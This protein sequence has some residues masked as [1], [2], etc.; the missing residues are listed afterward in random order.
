[1]KTL[2]VVFASIAVVMLAVTIRTS[3]MEP[4][5]IALPRILQDPWTVATFYDTY[6]AFLTIWIW[7]AYK[8]KTWPSRI[9]WLVLVLTLGNIATS[10]YILIQLYRLPKNAPIQD[11]LL[12]Q[13]S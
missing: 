11:L 5:W 8:E 10:L 7:M 3:L 6:F 4:V 13:G 9:L 2:R 12:R 1:M